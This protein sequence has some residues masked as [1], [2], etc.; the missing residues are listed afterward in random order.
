[1]GNGMATVMIAMPTHRDLPPETVRSLLDTQAACFRAGI[2]FYG[3]FGKGSSLVHHSRS[4][5]AW[6]FL[7]SDCSHI[8]WID[9]D[10]EW[11]ADSFMR[12]LA[13]ATVKDIVAAAY[14]FRRDDPGGFFIEFEGETV[15]AD[16]RGCLP[17]KKLGLGFCCAQ[18][19]V[20]EELAERAPKARFMDINGG[21]PIPHIFRLGIADG[22]MA[23]G[24]DVAFFTDVRALGY[25]INVDPTIV[26]GHIGPKVFRGRLMDHLSRT[27]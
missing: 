25:T 4:K 16:D 22:D 21:E 27:A 10:Q 3:E 24:E 7:Q 17:A 19:H 9:S 2:D 6:H 12:I 26:L 5:I 8:F 18:R 13:L 20:I 1:M 11:S 23:E 15:E 14:P